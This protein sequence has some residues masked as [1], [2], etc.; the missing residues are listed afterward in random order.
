MLGDL[1]FDGSQV[2]GAHWLELEARRRSHLY[3]GTFDMIFCF[4][5]GLT[6]FIVVPWINFISQL[7]QEMGE[8]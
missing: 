3:S 4:L 7:F 8:F 5:H 2:D 6:D 1:L